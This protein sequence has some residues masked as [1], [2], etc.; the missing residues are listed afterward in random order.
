MFKLLWLKKKQ[1]TLYVQQFLVNLNRQAFK[2]KTFDRTKVSQN[3]E[4]F[5]SCQWMIAQ[6]VERLFCTRQTRVQIPAPA[7]YEITLLVQPVLMVISCPIK[8]TWNGT[9]NRVWPTGLCRSK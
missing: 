3:I 2:V 7:S 6:M 8:K 5:Y 4:L 9:L 1:T